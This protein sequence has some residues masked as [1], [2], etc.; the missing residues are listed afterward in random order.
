MSCGLSRTALNGPI[1]NT[2]DDNTS[3]DKEDDQTPEP[4][5]PPVTS[6][7]GEWVFNLNLLS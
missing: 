1:E 3:S 2:V 6:F 7:S 5:L 4:E